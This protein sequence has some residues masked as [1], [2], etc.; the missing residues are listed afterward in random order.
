[1]FKYREGKVLLDDDKPEQTKHNLQANLALKQTARPK[2]SMP[3]AIVDDAVE[4][5][6]STFS[7]EDASDAAWVMLRHQPLWAESFRIP[8]KA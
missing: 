5:I 8:L 4:F 7:D 3:A 1:L 2:N 6:P